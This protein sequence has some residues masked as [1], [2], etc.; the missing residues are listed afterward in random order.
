ML[1]ASLLVSVASQAGGQ[2]QAT[3]L[4]R[5]DVALLAEATAGAAALTLLDARVA[6]ALSDSGCRR[7]IRASGPRRTGRAS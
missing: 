5:H 4:S 7:D 6:R 1:T 3:V 2:Q